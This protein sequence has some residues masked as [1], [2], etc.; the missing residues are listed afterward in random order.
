MSAPRKIVPHPL[1]KVANPQLTEDE[2]LNEAQLRQVLDEQHYRV[3]RE[4]MILTPEQCLARAKEFGWLAQLPDAPV[5]PTDYFKEREAH[6][7]RLA[8]LLQ[9]R[10]QYLDKLEK[11]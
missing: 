8:G 9:R 11:L 1:P 10:Q 6:Y 3:R 5:D 4:M 2:A 7:L